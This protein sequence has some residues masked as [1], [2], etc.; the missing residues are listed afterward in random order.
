MVTLAILP[1]GEAGAD[2]L[3]ALQLDDGTIV[4]EHRTKFGRTK[5]YPIAAHDTLRVSSEIWGRQN[6]ETELSIVSRTGSSIEVAHFECTASKGVHADEVGAFAISVADASGCGVNVMPTKER[7]FAAPEFDSIPPR[8]T[9]TPPPSVH[10]R[11]RL[12]AE[13]FATLENLDAVALPDGAVVVESSAYGFVWTINAASTL[14]VWPHEGVACIE[15]TLSCLEQSPELGDFEWNHKTKTGI[16]PDAV[17]AFA[18]AIAQRTGC[19]IHVEELQN[20]LSPTPVRSKPPP[21]PPPRPSYVYYVDRPGVE[22]IANLDYLNALRLPDG[23]VIIERLPAGIFCTVSASDT[24]LIS[25][26]EHTIGTPSV[27]TWIIR[28]GV[29][30]SLGEFE[31]DPVTKAGISTDDVLEFARAVSRATGCNVKNEPR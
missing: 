11:D 3:S 16:H 21:A 22:V 1:C 7:T 2:S 20:R 8:A 25:P 12:G 24:L 28:I 27:E 15:T 4:L 29:S 9:P 18:D 23:T 13:V 31:W 17:R 30:G 6:M 19:A 14:V 10:F 5:R 26:W